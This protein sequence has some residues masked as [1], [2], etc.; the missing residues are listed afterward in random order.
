M[1]RLSNGLLIFAIGIWGGVGVN[2]L[3]AAVPSEVFFSQKVETNR[4]RSHGRSLI[5]NNRDFQYLY[6]VLKKKSFNSDRLEL[7][8]VGVL[9]NYFSCRQCVEIMSLCSFD[10]DR[11][12][13]FE[14]M[15]SH[16]V[17]LENADIIIESLKF[18]SNQ[19]KAV[20]LLEKETGG[21]SNK[22]SRDTSR[23]E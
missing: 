22:R 10:D 17:D 16:I 21:Y 23:M 20:K 13:V 11:L 2:L 9:D 18:K 1:R 8:S 12:E 4:H 5:M 7:L 3:N 19:E 15:V 14:I 6:K